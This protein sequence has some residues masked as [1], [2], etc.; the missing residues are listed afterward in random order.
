M[1]KRALITGVTGQDGS[2]LSELLLEEGYEVFGIQRR[3]SSFNSAR[4]DHLLEPY[5]IA[6]TFY[7]DLTDANS[8]I[9]VLIKAN[10]DEIY[11]LGAQSHVKVSF[12]KPVYTADTNALGPLRILEAVRALKLKCKYY[13]AS[14]SEMFGITPPPQN[15]ASLFQPQSPYGCAKL[16]GFWITRC[17]RSG[18][19]IFAANGILFNHESPR[20]GETFVTKKIVRTAVR[21]KL[22][23]QDKIR[24]GNLDAM[25]DWGHSRDYMRAIHAIMQHGVPDDFVVATGEHYSVRDFAERVFSNLGLVFEDYLIKSPEYLR[26][27]EV[28]SLC[29]DSTKIRTVLGWKP[30]VSYEQLIDEMVKY[31]YDDEVKRG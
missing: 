26:P 15:E 4:I 3:S 11:N 23:K 1:K 28:P 14:S 19:N 13:Q 10:P 27:N 12:D 16:F 22:K 18:Y 24:L 9:D 7:A 6:R 21:I 25:R 29:G 31:C 17:Y 5:E 20:R 30:K 2:Y 8:I